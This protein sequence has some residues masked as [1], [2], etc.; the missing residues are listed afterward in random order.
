MFY[1]GL[2]KFNVLLAELVGLVPGGS[3]KH[4]ALH[5]LENFRL[6]LNAR[7][8]HPRAKCPYRPIH[9]RGRNRFYRRAL[10]VV[11]EFNRC[12]PGDDDIYWW[13]IYKLHILFPLITLS[14]VYMWNQLLMS[15]DAN[16]V[17]RKSP[18]QQGVCHIWGYLNRALKN[19]AVLG[20]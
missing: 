20:I 17:D 8:R 12:P 15:V 14:L 19:T 2:N 18:L 13:G 5:P 6:P 9:R 7:H 11:C 3:L 1:K 4:A 10:W 16:P